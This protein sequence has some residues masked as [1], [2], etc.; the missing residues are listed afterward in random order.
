MEIEDQDVYMNEV[1]EVITS[2]RKV[3]EQHSDDVITKKYQH[4]SEPFKC[5]NNIERIDKKV[6][7]FDGISF[8][9]S[10]ETIN[11]F[12]ND[13]WFETKKDFEAHLRNYS[14]EIQTNNFFKNDEDPF[15]Y[16]NPL[17]IWVT[18]EFRN[19]IRFPGEFSLEFVGEKNLYKK[20]TKQVGLMGDKILN[21]C[22]VF[23]LIYIIEKPILKRSTVDLNLDSKR[24]EMQ[25]LNELFLNLN[26][27]NLSI[28]DR[29]NYD[30]LSNQLS[31]FNIDRQYNCNDSNTDDTEI[32]LFMINKELN[33]CLNI[34][35]VIYMVENVFFDLN[36]VD[37]KK[38]FRIPS[39]NVFLNETIIPLLKD[40]MNT[41]KLSSTNIT[42]NLSSA[43][44]KLFNCEIFNCFEIENMDD[45]SLFSKNILNNRFEG[46]VF[47]ERVV[48]PHNNGDYTITYRNSK[49]MRYRND[50]PDELLYDS[51][52]ILK[53]ARW[54]RKNKLRTG[55]TGLPGEIRYRNKVMVQISFYNNN[56]KYHSFN[57]RPS[58][59]VY[60]NNGNLLREEYHL[61]GIKRKFIQYNVDDRSFI[62]RMFDE[63]GNEIE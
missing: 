31:S 59:I 39:T 56:E 38:Y 35:E 42:L 62:V 54:H 53:E 61:N 26:I 22:K 48:E 4:F 40:K 43:S 52:N 36:T 29:K 21:N 27:G 60:D 14:K 34:N 55:E 25:D 44:E 13:I 10:N 8:C 32:F 23:K 46:E 18:R 58:V 30:D 16:I 7:K 20:E 51:D 41:F 50:L 1:K 45:S 33:Y 19:T 47:L 28:N 49:Y 37:K 2:K 3:F 15:Y 24:S 63:K 11:G 9:F 6:I 17:D 57:G 5:H 12:L